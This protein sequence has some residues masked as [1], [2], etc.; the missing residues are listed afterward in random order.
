MTA[1]SPLRRAE[2]ERLTENYQVRQDT[3]EQA[4]RSL[5]AIKDELLRIDEMWAV[6]AS[7]PDHM[8]ATIDLLESAGNSLAAERNR[9]RAVT[10]VDA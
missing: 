4:L 5:R 1:L 9:C 7:A 3:C 6:E 2:H 10:G 8:S